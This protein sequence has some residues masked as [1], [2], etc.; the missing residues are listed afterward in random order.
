MEELQI[1]K[2]LCKI[3][4]L[5][6]KSF[7]RHNKVIL[8]LYTFNNTLQLHKYLIQGNNRRTIFITAQAMCTSLSHVGT[9]FVLF[10][11]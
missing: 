9:F 8:L 11:D 10:R 2:C 1:S 7:P 6:K 3:Y 5:H 4:H